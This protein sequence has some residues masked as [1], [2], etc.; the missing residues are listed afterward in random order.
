MLTAVAF[1]EEP[2]EG[3]YFPLRTIGT[4]FELFTQCINDLLKRFNKAKQIL[5]I[6]LQ[7]FLLVSDQAE[8]VQRGQATS[9]RSP[10]KSG[11]RSGPPA[12]STQ[13]SALPPLPGFLPLTRSQSFSCGFARGC[14]DLDLGRR[15]ERNVLS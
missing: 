1:G 6:L 3:M 5:I 7:L 10:S 11:G 15:R 13:V 2:E 9:Q 8:E 12:W 14:L 4:Q